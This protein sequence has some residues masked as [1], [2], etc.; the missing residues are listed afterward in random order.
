MKEDT[1]GLPQLEVLICTIG[2]EGIKRVVKSRH[3]EVEGVRYLVA[4]QQPDG[5]IV[6]PEELKCR[7][8]FKVVTERSR[9]ISRNRNFALRS[10]EAPWC[11]MGDD[12]VDYDATGL[13]LLIDAI[14]EAPDA[15]ILTT[16][17]SC[18]GE[19]VKTYPDGK[20]CLRTKVKN[21]FVSAIEI[22]MRR[23]ALP[24]KVSFNENISIGTPK[25]RS[26]EENVFMYDALRA[27]LRGYFVPVTIGA[28]DHPSTSERDFVTPNFIFSHGAVVSHICPY[29]WL[30]RLILHAFRAK[31]SHNV[32]IC[33]ALRHSFSGVFYAFLS[34]VF[35]KKHALTQS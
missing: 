20:V 15:D 7:A 2:E 14:R 27:G 32:G 1:N 19:F 11:L 28:H 21:Y 12:D 31:K 3:P 18:C 17:Y 29:T 8:D 10:A 25:I 35:R 4:W 34:G 13:R 6:V 9:G 5:D 33:F 30:P 16:R 23:E 24:G 22:A 26:G